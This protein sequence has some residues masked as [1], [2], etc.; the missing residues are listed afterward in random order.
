MSI[1]IQPIGTEVL[2]MNPVSEEKTQK[3]KR[4]ISPKIVFSTLAAAGIT[5]A[6]VLALKN[7]K[8]LNINEIKKITGKNPITQ[9]LT[10]EEKEKLIKELQAK[11][12]NPEVKTEIRK[13]IENGEWDR[14]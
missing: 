5:T 12:D 14:L 8:N 10:P 9:N 4:N 6:A 3:E 11:T 2:K 1:Q 7:K 13:L